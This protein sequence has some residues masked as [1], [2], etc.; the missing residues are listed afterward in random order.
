M[1]VAINLCRNRHNVIA[2]GMDTSFILRVIAFGGTV[3][4]GLVYDLL[5]SRCGGHLIS[6]QSRLAGLAIKDWVSVVP[7]LCGSTFGIIFFFIFASQ[8]DII[9]LWRCWFEPCI[10]LMF[11]VGA[12]VN[13][14]ALALIGSDSAKTG[15]SSD[16]LELNPVS[17]GTSIHSQPQLATTKDPSRDVRYKRGE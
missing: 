14:R 11:E 17:L 13:F 6:N 1:L 12:D 9:E 3:L 4:W 10:T 5:C 7:D 2:A 16:R 15:G 8:K